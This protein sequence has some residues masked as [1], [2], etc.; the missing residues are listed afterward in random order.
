MRQD[1]IDKIK[2]LLDDQKLSYRLNDIKKLYESDYKLPYGYT[3]YHGGVMADCH[4]DLYNRN[5]I[6]IIFNSINGF[7]KD[8]TESLKNHNHF[9]IVSHDPKIIKMELE[10]Q[11]ESKNIKLNSW[12]L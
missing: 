2:K 6:E 7:N 8:Y 12:R 3:W 10:K 4:T 9:L 1:I 11:N 5:C